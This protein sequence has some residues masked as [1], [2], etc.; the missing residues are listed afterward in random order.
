M[1][2]AASLGLILLLA[3]C[4]QAG[5]EEATNVTGNTPV[6]IEAV[7]ADESAVTPT[8]E[9]ENGASESEDSNLGNQY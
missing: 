1:Q 9:L 3:A 8:E 6:D 2:N 5:T 7:P 4:G